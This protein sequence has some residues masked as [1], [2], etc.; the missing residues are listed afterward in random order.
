MNNVIKY[1]DRDELIEK[2]AS[3]ISN[4]LAN[5][6]DSSQSVTFAVPGG[7]HPDQY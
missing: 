1:N 7:S 2:V 5:A 3:K 6:L 4:D